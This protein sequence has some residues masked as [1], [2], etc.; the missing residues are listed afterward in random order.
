MARGGR[1]VAATAPALQQS[2]P[3]VRTPRKSPQRHR[4]SLF[5]AIAFAWHCRTNRRDRQSFMLLA[6]RKTFATYQTL[7]NLNRI[8]LRETTVFAFF[9]TDRSNCK[10]VT[11]LQISQKNM[12]IDKKPFNRLP[13]NIKPYNYK[14]QLHP[15]LAS[16]TFK[17]KQDIFVEV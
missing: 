11:E 9:S 8:K 15:D 2:P 3:P 17:G 10:Q 5:R 4:A 12:A 7:S 16:F 13:K 6:I 14:I 1:W